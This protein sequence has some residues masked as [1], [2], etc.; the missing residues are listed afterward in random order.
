VIGERLY[1][2]D[3]RLPAVRVFDA[4]TGNEQSA[5][6]TSDE[7]T[8]HPDLSG[9]GVAATAAGNLVVSDSVC[10]REFTIEDG[11]TTFGVPP[12][13]GIR[14]KPTEV[15]T[16]NCSARRPKAELV[17][18]IADVKGGCSVAV[19]KE[20][21]VAVAVPR[22]QYPGSEPLPEVWKF[23]AQGQAVLRVMFVYM[24]GPAD[25]DGQLPDSLYK[26][27]VAGGL[28]G[29]MRCPGG[30]AFDEQGRLYISDS[31]RWPKSETE[32]HNDT[33][34]MEMDGGIV[35]YSADGDLEARLGSRYTNGQLIKARLDSRT[36]RPP[37]LRTAQAIQAGK[38]S[39]LA[40]GDSITQCGGTTWNGGASK[41]ENNWVH[42]LARTMEAKHPGLTVSEVADGVGGQNAAQSLCR[43]P[44]AVAARGT[45]PDLILIQLGTNEQV[46]QLQTP[47]QFTASLRRMLTALIVTT[48]SDLVLVSTGPIL[49]SNVPDPPEVY[50]RAMQAVGKEFGVPVVDINAAMQRRLADGTPFEKFH[51]GPRN[52]HPN[53]AGHQVWA[54]AVMEVLENGL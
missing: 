25:Y 36:G 53:D 30:V 47:A 6:L 8:M 51:L 1:V 34:R 48:D 15:G 33:D 18:K 9:I 44:A 13:G 4:A 20:G 27:R 16:P 11:K 26:L 17:R 23:N 54:E 14:E 7:L 35:R 45:N 52:S 31:L 42:V 41:T 43:N 3:R 22:S 28:I 37:L 12:S 2:G 21:N 5:L 50:L 19:D 49:D 32:F 29:A 24:R 39:L 40:W 46:F 38:L 10:V